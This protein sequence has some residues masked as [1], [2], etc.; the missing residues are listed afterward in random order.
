MLTSDF[1]IGIVSMSTINLFRAMSN[2]YV[3]FPDGTK[4][5]EDVFVFE[6]NE[7]IKSCDG[8][9]PTM[10]VIHTGSGIC[11]LVNNIEVESTSYDNIL[12]RAFNAVLNKTKTK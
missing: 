3:P 5:S 6:M 7:S 10:R 1:T 11:L 12:Y 4:L 9:I 8:Y 2:A